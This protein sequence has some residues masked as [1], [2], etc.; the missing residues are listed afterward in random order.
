MKESNKES[1][2][3]D[4]AKEIKERY[5]NRRLRRSARDLLGVIFSARDVVALT[6]VYLCCVPLSVCGVVFVPLWM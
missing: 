5:K 6:A 1:K 3:I 2:E 4:I